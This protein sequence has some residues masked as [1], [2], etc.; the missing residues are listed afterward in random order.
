MHFVQ[1]ELLQNHCL[2]NERKSIT[3]C[4]I[5]GNRKGELII[6]QPIKDF[7]K[8]DRI[9]LLPN[10]NSSFSL[11]A[12]ITKN[13]QLYQKEALALHRRCKDPLLGQSFV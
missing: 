3:F 4:R 10:H 8:N 5:N 12:K 9:G 11:Y 6:R 1:Y 13:Y 7:G 2:K